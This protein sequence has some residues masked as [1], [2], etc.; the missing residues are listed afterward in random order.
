[1]TCAK[2]PYEVMRQTGQGNEIRIGCFSTLA[3]ARSAA[4]DG[5]KPRDVSVVIRKYSFAHILGANNPI[6]CIS[7]ESILR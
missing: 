3:A 1:M 6:G 2:S 5:I 7:I 4:I